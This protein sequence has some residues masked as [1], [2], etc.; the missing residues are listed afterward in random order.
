MISSLIVGCK[1]NPEISGTAK[2]ERNLS[3]GESPLQ[4]MDILFPQGYTKETPV[5]FLIHG[6][7]F[8]AGVKEDFEMQAQK[9]RQQNFIVVNLSHRLIDTAG[10]LRNPPIHQL[11]AIKV[12]DEVKDM[13]AAVKYYMSHAA[14]YNAGT[15]RMF[16]AGHSAGATLSMLYVQ[17]ELNKDGHVRASANW[18]GLTDMSIADPNILSKLDARWVELLYRTTGKM[19][20]EENALYFMAIS[21]YWVSNQQGG[22]PNISIFPEN[23]IVFQVAGE[24]EYQYQTTKNYH[25]LLKDKGVA[26][27]LI[28][29]AGED[30]GFGTKPGSWDKLI[31]ETADFFKT[32]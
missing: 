16:M 3:Y 20:S 30:H 2:E 27:K 28:Y 6:G 11:S 22:M 10:L 29:Y 12:S 17:G 15:R 21:P 1:K 19:P 26:E 13:D 24:K 31:K 7:G 18:A 9:F 23:N 32:N 25:G 14:A 8:I 4:K 5:V